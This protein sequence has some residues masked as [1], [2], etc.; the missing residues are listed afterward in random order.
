MLFIQHRK[1]SFRPE[2]ASFKPIGGLGAS[3][4]RTPDMSVDEMIESS[5]DGTERGESRDEE[6]GWRDQ[7]YLQSGPITQ[8]DL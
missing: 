3:S 2:R 6:K 4:R 5:S 1:D 8:R 7:R